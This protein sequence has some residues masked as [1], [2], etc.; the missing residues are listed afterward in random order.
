MKLDRALEE[1][2]LQVGSFERIVLLN[3]IVNLHL[4]QVAAYGD[5]HTT[6]VGKKMDITSVKQIESD[7]RVIECWIFIRTK[8]FTCCKKTWRAF[9][10]RGTRKYSVWILSKK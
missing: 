1:A 2:A 7:D 10:W 8:R 9:H 4:P 3:I 5:I 6:K